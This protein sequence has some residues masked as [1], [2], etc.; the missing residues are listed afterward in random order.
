MLGFSVVYYTAK[1]T[2]HLVVYDAINKLKCLILPF[3]NVCLNHS[4]RFL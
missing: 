2:W 4:V 1:L 3:L